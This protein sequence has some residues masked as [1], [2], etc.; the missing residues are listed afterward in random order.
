M[1]LK[2]IHGACLPLLL[3]AR[4]LHAGASLYVDDAATT[5]EG[6]CQVESWVRTYAPGREWSTLPACTRGGNEY[7]LGVSRFDR[8][9]D[10]LFTPGVKRTLRDPDGQA[11]GAAVF[12]G[13]LWDATHGRLDGWNANLPVTLTLMPGKTLLHVNLGWSKL[14][15]VRGMPTAG[16]G[17]E[18]RLA[19][20]WSLLAEAYA[21]GNGDLTRQLGARAAFGESVSVDLLLGR[22]TGHRPGRWF[23]L[24]LNVALPD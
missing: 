23:T 22:S 21:D 16:L 24:G 2:P 3:A 8:P 17:L 18:H 10:V 19:G 15:G 7:S 14:H 9:R 5:P 11:W 13:A 4:T 1:K 20:H 12:V 6:R